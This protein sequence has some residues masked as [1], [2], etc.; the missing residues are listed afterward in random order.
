MTNIEA[1]YHLKN[2]ELVN[3]FIAPRSDDFTGK[4]FI[5]NIAAQARVNA[6]KKLI[7]IVVSID[8]KELNKDEDLG[9]IQTAVA[10]EI[11]NFDEVVKLVG[12]KLY[13]IQTS[14]EVLLRTISI[15]TTRGIMWSHFKGTHLNG[16]VLP[17]I[18]Q[19]VT[20]QEQDKL[21]SEKAS[22]VETKE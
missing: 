21:D 12:D 7:F 9:K 14:L 6:D 18:P 2:I 5:F 11:T 19:L 16:A 1:R 10:F 22:E 3:L 20:P 17:V 4:E 15:S 13:E 8:T